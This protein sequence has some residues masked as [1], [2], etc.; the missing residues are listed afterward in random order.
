[1]KARDLAIVVCLFT[2]GLL[3]AADTPDTFD[4][5][6]KDAAAARAANH[7][8]DAVR[9]YQQALAMRPSW[10]E[11]WWFLGE[12]LYDQD[13]YPE[14]RDAL[15]R[16]VALDPK[17]GPGFALLGLCE[18]Q[19]REYERALADINQGRRLGLGE[20]DQVKRVVLF[21]A[22]ALFTRAGMYESALELL[23]QIIN[24][25]GSGKA[26]LDAAGLAGLR[27][28]I[29]PEDL[30]ADEKEL[31][32]QAG[33]AVY[34]YTDHH[35]DEAQKYFTVLVANY[36]KTPNV[37]YLYGTFLLASDAQAGLRELQKELELNPKHGE[38][39]VQIALEYVQIGE[40]DKA[41]TY[42]KR[43]V[44][45]APQFF[46]AHAVLGRL[47]AKAGDV[48]KAIQELELARSQAPDSPQV[49][50]VLASVYAMAGRDDDAARE[51]AEFVRL[52][53]LADETMGN[54]ANS[55]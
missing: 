1:M 52:K 28:P 25:G 30:G 33:K 16:L 37:H 4:T 26:V 40:P 36:P 55:R 41:L 9:L 19:T 44:D 12:L 13:Q 38:A 50:F 21:H 32:E 22:M 49:H 3:R 39:L 27:R 46:A 48:D 51:R 10:P 43:A 20:D 53:K 42:A 7:A 14:A 54:N 45:A 35:P 15:R 2:A 8:Q 6:T 18:Y 31:I 17:A 34:A 29:L 23:S 24:L 47:L 5:V 11:G